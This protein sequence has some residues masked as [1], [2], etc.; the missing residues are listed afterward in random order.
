[1]SGLSKLS[2]LKQMFREKVNKEAKTQDSEEFQLRV[3]SVLE[4]QAHVQQYS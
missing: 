3:K 1:M 4:S 2:K